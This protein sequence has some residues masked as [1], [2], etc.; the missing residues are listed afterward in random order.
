[1]I[2]ANE[3]FTL[4]MVCQVNAQTSR[5]KLDVEFTETTRK[6]V[7]AR[8]ARLLLLLVFVLDREPKVRPLS[9]TLGL[10]T[11]GGIGFFSLE[12]HGSSI[13]TIDENVVGDTEWSDAASDAWREP[14][15]GGL[16]GFFSCHA[17][18]R[19]L[20]LSKE[21]VVDLD[22]SRVRLEEERLL[23]SADDESSA[24]VGRASCLVPRVA[25]V[26]FQEANTEHVEE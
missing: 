24:L 6:F 26:A 14:A 25:G 10:E 1:M 20:V 23:E 15:G 5:H 21:S 13:S 19:I 22:V 3:S 8:V 16:A 17:A 2:T 18:H 7:D 9:L 12:H 11:S 4:A